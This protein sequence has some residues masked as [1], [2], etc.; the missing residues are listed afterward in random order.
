MKKRLKRRKFLE[1]PPEVFL[2]RNILVEFIL[3]NGNPYYFLL[4]SSHCIPAALQKGLEWED[5]VRYD[6]STQDRSRRNPKVYE[7]DED[8]GALGSA[9]SFLTQ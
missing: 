8:L 6:L 4:R 7:P 1:E 3:E 2:A 9:R 5:D